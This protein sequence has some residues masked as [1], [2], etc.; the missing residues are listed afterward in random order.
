MT[1]IWM[2][3]VIWNFVLSHIITKLNLTLIITGYTGFPLMSIRL[4]DEV[5]N[6]VCDSVGVAGAE[7]GDG[8]DI[9]ILDW[10]ILLWA[11]FIYA[12]CCNV[13]E[14]RCEKTEVVN[15]QKTGLQLCHRNEDETVIILRDSHLK[16]YN[17]VVWRLT[18]QLQ[19]LVIH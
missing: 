18:K 13:V 4:S 17:S 7:Y 15:R 10:W 5:D 12:E 11:G 1:I 8:G 14:I 9:K 16:I 3:E 6:W 19:K 2:F